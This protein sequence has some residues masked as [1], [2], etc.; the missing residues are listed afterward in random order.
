ML[1][2][3]TSAGSSPRAARDQI[4]RA[5]HREG[6]FRPPGAAIGRVRHLVGGDD[7]ARGGEVLDLVGAGQVDRGVVG[8]ARADRVPGAAIDDVVVAER[9]DAALVVEPD[10]DIVQLVAR[11]RRGHEMLAPVLDPAHRPAEAAREE[12]DQQVLGIDVALAAEAAADIERDEAH[13]LL[14]EA[15]DRGDLA[16]HPMHD[17][18][19]RPDRHRRRCAGRRRRRRRGIPSAPRRS[20]GGRSGASGGA[21]RR[22]APPRHR[23]CR[24]KTR[25]SGWC[26]NARGRCG[27]PGRSAA[28]GS[29]T[30]GSSSR[31]RVTSSAA[32]SA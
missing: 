27:A 9:E 7:P 20:G 21:A 12:R 32:S 19:R 11:M 13:A 31:S 2:R 22:R 16:A 18:G 28:S 15:E 10:L 30:A 26:R 5:L 25:R 1:R 29:T 6:G 4:D 23:P 3:R 24:P 14:G 17:L 8:D